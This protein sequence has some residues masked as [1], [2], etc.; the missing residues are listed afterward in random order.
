MGPGVIESPMTA[1]RPDIRDAVAALH[2]I[3][4]LGR[5]REVA[6]VVGFL[7][8]DEASFV[9]GAFYSVDGG[10]TAQ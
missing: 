6:A 3:G 10:Y 5:P 8:S 9:T 1:T 4:R 2:P 7:L